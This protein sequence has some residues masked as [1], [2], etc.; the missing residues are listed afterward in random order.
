MFIVVSNK[1]W[2]ACSSALLY[3]SIEQFNKAVRALPHTAVDHQ[4]RTAC[5]AAHTRPQSMGMGRGGQL[6]PSV[7]IDRHYTLYVRTT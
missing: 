2:A 7:V 4:Q 1:M 3:A 6:R 5:S